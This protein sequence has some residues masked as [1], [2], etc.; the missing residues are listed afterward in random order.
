M[1]F[2][3]A[4][5]LL[6]AQFIQTQQPPDHEDCFTQEAMC[7]CTVSRAYYAAFCHAR[8]YAHD[9]LGYR[10]RGVDDNDHYWLRQWLHKKNRRDESRWLG[11]LHNWRTQCDYVDSIDAWTLQLMCNKSI[12]KARSIISKL[13]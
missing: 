5:Y 12:T 6:L 10:I 3:W 13:S 8:N 11:E 9:R 7:R 1:A 2:R 4:E